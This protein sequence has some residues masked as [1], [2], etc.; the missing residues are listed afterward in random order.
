MRAYLCVSECVCVCVCVSCLCIKATTNSLV[1]FLCVS[2]LS[3]ITISLVAAKEHDVAVEL[4]RTMHAHIR[5]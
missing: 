4:P 2:E 3:P 1:R 5:L